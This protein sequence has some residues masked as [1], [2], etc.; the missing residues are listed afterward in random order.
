MAEVGE[1]TTLNVDVVLEE[2]FGGVPYGG[3][4]E[5]RK[6]VTKKLIQNEKKEI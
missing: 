4:H 5:S 6:R 2:S 3:D 1:R